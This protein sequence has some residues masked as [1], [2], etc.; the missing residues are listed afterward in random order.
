MFGIRK[1]GEK[2]KKMK[3]VVEV[4]VSNKMQ[5]SM[6]VVVDRL[7][8]HKLFNMSIGLTFEVG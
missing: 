5:K 6:V 7:F 1:E 2:R 8:H 3:P 4:V